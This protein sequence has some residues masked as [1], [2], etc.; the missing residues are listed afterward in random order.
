MQSETEGSAKLQVEICMRW[1]PA[2]AAYHP[3][4]QKIETTLDLPQR[5]FTTLLVPGCVLTLRFDPSEKGDPSR[6]PLIVTWPL[7]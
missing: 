2:S 5:F 6:E 7:P 3:V 1:L 4:Q